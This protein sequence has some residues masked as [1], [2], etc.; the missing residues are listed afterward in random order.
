M[1]PT[2]PA[3]RA[4]LAVAALSVLVLCGCAA[5]PTIPDPHT[6]QTDGEIQPIH[7]G[8]D[9]ANRVIWTDVLVQRFRQEQPLRSVVT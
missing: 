4:L 9:E 3:Q 2:M 8:I 7:K 5:V 6:V 1:I